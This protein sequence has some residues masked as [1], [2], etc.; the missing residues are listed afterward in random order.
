[1]SPRKLR[2][3]LSFLL[4]GTAILAVLRGP[5]RGQ[6]DWDVPKKAADGPMN[7]N[8]VQQGQWTLPNFD[9]W[10]LRGRSRDQFESTLKSLLALQ[11]QNVGRACQLSAAQREKLELAG[12]CD[13]KRTSRQIDKLREE[14]RQAAQ[15]QE[16]YSRL[17]NEGSQMQM[18]LQTGIYGDSSLYQKVL[19]QTLN[20]EQSQGYERQER[21]RRK[22]RYEAKIELV[23]SNLESTISLT[24][25]QR[26]RLVK[27]LVDETEPPRKFGQYDMYVVFMQLGKLSDEKLKPI[28]DE[29]Q[30][31]SLARLVNQYRGM[32]QMLKA[33]G[34][35]D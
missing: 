22:F 20:G 11:V 18:A 17:I 16:T 12:E 5:A 3:A 32:E 31:Q 9:Q 14:F 23:M 34:V 13:L 15:D 24:V 19:R 25:E 30:R 6:D 10:V 8:F 28:L 27:L 1:M 26:Q 21:L 2:L 4:G 7:G 33:Q 29:S 35:L